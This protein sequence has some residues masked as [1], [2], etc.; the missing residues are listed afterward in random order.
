MCSRSSVALAVLAVCVGHRDSSGVARAGCGGMLQGVLALQAANWVVLPRRR[1]R[2]CGCHV[3]QS[4]ALM[5]R[6]FARVRAQGLCALHKDFARV[7]A[8]N[9]TRV[10]R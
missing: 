7:R 3:A 2:M 8:Q 5:H 9:L 4:V 10:R 1:V 6:D